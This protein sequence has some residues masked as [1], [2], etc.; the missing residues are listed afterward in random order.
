MTDEDALA[1]VVWAFAQT[2]L[3]DQFP[4]NERS[5]EAPVDIALALG[6]AADHDITI[7][8][9]IVASVTK[10]FAT[11]DDFDAQ[12]VMAQ[13]ANAVRVTA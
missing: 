6:G 12:Q 3:P 10:C 8:D 5:G 11:R 2:T 9:S 4:D 13:L 1:D 7:P